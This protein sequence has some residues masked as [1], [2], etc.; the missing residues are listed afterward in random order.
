VVYAIQLND[1][2]I[3]EDRIRLVIELYLNE[4]QANAY[5]G[6]DCAW[7]ERDSHGWNF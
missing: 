4:T 5:D 3:L 1:K 7:V 6:K 2:Q